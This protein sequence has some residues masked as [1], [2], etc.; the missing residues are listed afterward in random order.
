M[1]K[2][3]YAKLQEA[4]KRLNDANLQKT[5]KNAFGAGFKYFELKDFMPA[6]NDIFHEIGL[7][8]ITDFSGESYA[9]LRIHDTQQE[10]APIEFSCLKA[11]AGLRQGT[12]IQNIG[13]QQTYVRRYLWVQAMEITEDDQVDALADDKKVSILD[14]N[15][16]LQ[17]PA[18][19]TP[20]SETNW[21]DAIYGC[22]TLAQLSAV[23]S[24]I[25]SKNRTQDI[26]VKKDKKK[27]ELTPIDQQIDA[28]E[29]ME[30]VTAI[31]ERLTPEQQSDFEQI[32]SDKLDS[33]RL[34]ELQ[35][36]Q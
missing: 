14:H 17:K 6:I 18:P 2:S 29:T 28:A 21:T 11:E 35:G 22:Q 33:F 31:C 12:P 36:Q 24:S 34:N 23:W 19:A 30:Q 15:K 32:I 10:C 1:N 9:Y 26:I 3:I 5:G 16:Q 8:G 7:V 4:R 27:L 20:K 25:P 13:A